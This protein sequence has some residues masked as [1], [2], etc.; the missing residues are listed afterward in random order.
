MGRSPPE[1]PVIA[2]I[3]NWYR[4]NKVRRLRSSGNQQSNKRQ[5]AGS[6][7]L[8]VNNNGRQ[9]HHIPQAVVA[10]PS[11]GGAVVENNTVQVSNGSGR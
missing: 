6:N 5:V 7:P 1:P 4:N 9:N 8:Q 2:G 3:K 10:G 11:N